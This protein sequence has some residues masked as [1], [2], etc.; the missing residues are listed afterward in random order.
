MYK[1]LMVEDDAH[2]CELVSLYTDKAK[3]ELITAA[4]GEAGLAAYYDEE[5]DLV[6]LDIMLPERSGWELCR[7][8]RK[9]NPLLPILMLTGRGEADDIVRGLDIGADDYVVKPF[10]PNELM[11]RIHAL[12]RRAHPFS[13]GSLLSSGR[14]QVDMQNRELTAAGEKLLF[15]PR[16]LELLAFFMQYSG[17]TL[18]REQLLDA[19]WGRDFD[20]DPRTVDVH[21]KRIRRRL[22][23]VESGVQL[24]TVRQAGYRLEEIT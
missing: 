20:G 8:I 4:D 11:A 13:T 2:I 3:L 23:T 9:D 6:L 16:E 18:T 14:L 22:D 7:E 17:Q 5:P 15:P 12:L 1:L 19:V 21:V 24:V 10:D